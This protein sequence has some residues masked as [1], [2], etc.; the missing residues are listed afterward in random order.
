M[1]PHLDEDR[2][3]ACADLIDALKTCHSQHPWLKFMGKCNDR[4]QALSACL[5]AE[6]EKKRVANLDKAR[7]DK[8]RRD[9]EQQ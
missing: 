6:F 5:G 3:A 7:A 1:H 4:K 8:I 2:H 9:H